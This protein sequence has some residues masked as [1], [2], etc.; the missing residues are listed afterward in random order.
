MRALTVAFLLVATLA[1]N[2]QKILIPMDARTQ[3]DHL[4]V[5]GIAYWV[6]TR[7]ATG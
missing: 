7:W 6:L 5:Y 3:S 2:G 4:K 1:A